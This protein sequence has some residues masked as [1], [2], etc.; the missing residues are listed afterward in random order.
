MV[1][2]MA[3]ATPGSGAGGG[4]ELLEKLGMLMLPHAPRN[5]ASAQAIPRLAAPR[6]L[7]DLIMASPNVDFV[8]APIPQPSVKLLSEQ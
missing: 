4:L 3:G 8:A 1:A 2:G 5:T 6:A 7:T